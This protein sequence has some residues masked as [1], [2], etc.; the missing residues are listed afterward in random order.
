[1]PDLREFSGRLRPNPGAKELPP[2]TRLRL[3]RLAS[4][5]TLPRVRAS[6]C[7]VID[8]IALPREGDGGGGVYSPHRNGHR[9]IYL[10]ERVDAGLCR[11]RAERPLGGQALTIPQRVFLFPYR[12]T[13]RSGCAHFEPFELGAR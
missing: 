4:P 6:R 10:R 5:A 9:A 1:M 2:D 8:A 11:D 3:F 12:H 7:L 13:D